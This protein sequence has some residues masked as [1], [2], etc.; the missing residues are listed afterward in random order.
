[1]FLIL[2]IKFIGVLIF[3]YIN[4]PKRLKSLLKL[5]LCTLLLKYDYCYGNWSLN[6]PDSVMTIIY[7]QLS[8]FDFN[9]SSSQ[10]MPLPLFG[11]LAYGVYPFH[12]LSFLKCSSLWHLRASKLS[13]H[14]RLPSR[15]CGFPMYPHLNLLSLA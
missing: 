15:R 1:M 2:Y 13:I 12:H 5:A 14:L 3:Q 8:L 4:Y 10:S 11:L 6:K 7:L 9:L